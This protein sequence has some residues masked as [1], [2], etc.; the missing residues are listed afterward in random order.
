MVQGC[1]LLIHSG[2]H[3]QELSTMAQEAGKTNVAFLAN[4]LLQNV[5]ACIDI[6]VASSR[7]AEAAFF[8]RSYR[9][10]RVPELVKLWQE[11]L[12]QVCYLRNQF[13]FR[14]DWLC[15]AF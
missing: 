7:L 10:S 3:M 6:L 9:P 4:Y 14:S 11:D 8:A 15:D 12:R 13:C 2:L 1:S 5:D